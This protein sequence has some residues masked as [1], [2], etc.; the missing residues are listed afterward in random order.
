[1]LIRDL[2]VLVGGFYL[3]LGQLAAPP[4][5]SLYAKAAGCSFIF[6][7]GHGSDINVLIKIFVKLLKT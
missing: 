7:D 3:T 6:T 4:V 1:M 5:S 2:E